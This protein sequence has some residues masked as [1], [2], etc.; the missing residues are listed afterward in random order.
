MP[1]DREFHELEKW[2]EDMR[3]AFQ[4]L[5]SFIESGDAKREIDEAVDR[6]T[7]GAQQLASFIESGDAKREIDEMVRRFTAAI[8]HLGRLLPPPPS[9]EGTDPS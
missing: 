5:A 3:Q 4:Q 7:A 2:R 1:D 8:Q 9:D 6:F